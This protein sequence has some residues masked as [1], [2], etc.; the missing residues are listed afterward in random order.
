MF[1]IIVTFLSS[2]RPTTAAADTSSEVVKKIKD[3]FMKD[4]S[5]IIVK[6]LD[7]YRRPDAKR[8]HIQSTE[9][10]K[11]LAKKVVFSKQ[12]TI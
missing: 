1:L 4:A 5:K 7:P 2:S 10:F 8:G 12:A 11:H 9:D 3:R 6:L